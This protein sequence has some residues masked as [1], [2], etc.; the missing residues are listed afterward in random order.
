MAK[1]N[2]IKLKEIA[3]K[4]VEELFK[5]AQSIYKKN[6]K[7][8]NRYIDIARKTAMKVNLRLPRILKRKFCKH[9][10]AYLVPGE[11][12]RVRIHKSRVVYYCFSCKKYMRFVLN[13][14]TKKSAVQES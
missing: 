6:P 12:Y 2:K 4:R 10:Y 14:T 13:R 5:E 3:L 11:T 7:L 1:V 8:A 9:C